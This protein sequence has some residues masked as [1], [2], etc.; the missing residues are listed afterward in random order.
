MEEPSQKRTYSSLLQTTADLKKRRKLG[1]P[2]AQSRPKASL[3]TYRVV[4]KTDT[5]FYC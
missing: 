5:Q 2:R 4:Q 1:Q 3:C